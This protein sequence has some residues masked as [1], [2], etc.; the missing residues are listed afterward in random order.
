MPLPIWSPKSPTVGQ[1]LSL[2]LKSRMNDFSISSKIRNK[3]HLR[4]WIFQV[5]YVRTDPLEKLRSLKKK[6]KKLR[7]SESI[8][9]ENENIPTYLGDTEG[10]V[11]D[12]R[13]KAAISIKQ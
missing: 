7:V 4:L 6:Q 5:P 1:N 2:E 3:G 11:L 9:R 10:V 8:S 12:H 13:D